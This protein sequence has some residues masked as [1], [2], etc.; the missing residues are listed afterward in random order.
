MTINEVIVDFPVPE[1]DNLRH[2]GA[3]KEETEDDQEKPEEEGSENSE[4]KEEHAQNEA[5]ESEGQDSSKRGTP[6]EKTE[7]EAEAETE[8]QEEAE[9]DTEEFVMD[10]IISHRKNRL[11]ETQ[12]R[13]SR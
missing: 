8:A 10:R 9:P 11:E 3:S 12:V 2:I 7:T 13:G 5:T 6:T 1:K 4:P